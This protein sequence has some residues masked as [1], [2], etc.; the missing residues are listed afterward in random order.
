MLGR[1]EMHNIKFDKNP[2]RRSGV[3]AY[4]W[5]DIGEA[6]RRIFTIRQKASQLKQVPTQ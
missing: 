3:V 5:T 6:N 1:L 4:E 2:F